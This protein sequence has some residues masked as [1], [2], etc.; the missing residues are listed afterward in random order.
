MKC[1]KYP[2]GRRGLAWAALF[3]GLTVFSHLEIFLITCVWI[4]VTALFLSRDRWGLS[5][6][7]VIGAGLAL[8]SA[9]WWLSVT[10]YHGIGPFLRALLSG[11]FNLMVSLGELLLRNLSEE[12][13]FT[14]VLVFSMLGLAQRILKKDWLLP[15]WV[16][17]VVIFDPR[18]LERS[19]TLPL[20][21]LA[22]LAIHE[23]ILPS[24][25][26]VLPG[27]DDPQAPAQRS[28]LLPNLVSAVLLAYML[29]R[30]AVMSQL[31]VFSM[32][33]TLDVLSRDDRERDA[34]GH[35]AHTANQPLPGAH[36]ADHLGDQ[37]S[38]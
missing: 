6:A 10:I 19:L 15:A 7:A 24:L 18:S 27:S 33:H 20:S 17:A 14:P 29:I 21:M 34:V 13:L 25:N 35:G 16:L 1:R 37:R 9:P 11:E 22:G 38:G 8:L 3:A 23:M 36:A 28:R 2:A 4:A 26:A 30:T 12:F 31:Y 32:T 5:V